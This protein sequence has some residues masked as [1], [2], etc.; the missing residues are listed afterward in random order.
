MPTAGGV[1]VGGGGWVGELKQSRRRGRIQTQ[2]AR[3]QSLGFHSIL[4]SQEEGPWLALEGKLWSS[5]GLRVLANT[6]INGFPPK[7][8]AQTGGGAAAG[9]KERGKGQKSVGSEWGPDPALPQQPWT[10]ASQAGWAQE[11]AGGEGPS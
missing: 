2:T 4:H 8:L 7:G 9:S 6:H 5:G 11:E 10:T 1:G 3:I